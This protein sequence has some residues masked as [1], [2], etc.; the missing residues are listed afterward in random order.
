VTLASRLSSL[1][2]SPAAVYLAAVVLSRA[3]AFLLIPLYTRRLTLEEYGQYALFLTL[4]AFLSTLMSAGL[5]AALPKAY[6]SE[7]DRAAGKRHAAE[8]A[9]WLALISLGGAGILLVGVECV[10][11]P[12]WGDLLG[13][14]TLRLAILGG[15]GTAVSAVPWTLL[16]SEQRPYAASAFQLLQLP[17]ITG[18]GL[19]L[20][21]VL[22][23]GYTGAIEAAALAPMFTGVV[24]LVY[25]I[26][27]PK[28][29]MH[30]TR[31]RRSL[32]FALPFIPLGVL[33]I[34][35]LPRDVA[36]AVMGIY[37][38]VAAVLQVVSHGGAFIRAMQ[39]KT[40]F[41]ISAVLTGLLSGAF[42]A[43]GPASVPFFLSRQKNPLAGQANLSLFFSLLVFPVLGMHILIGGLKP[44]EIL[45]GLPYIPISALATWMAT[46]WIRRMNTRALQLI[47]AAAMALMGLYL[48]LSSILEF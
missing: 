46:R 45:A 14:D 12:D 25:I 38:I 20:V 29:G 9:R 23:R 7:D 17:A 18:A 40:A 43:P 48:A 15:A 35:R 41:G 6:F 19:F 42:S 13:R 44:V 2:R 36:I 47:V 33:F 11:A 21:L 32:R 30:L 34:S 8:V 22:D 27:L 39:T 4:L 24:S 37:V 10:A 28:S 5:V 16:R 31:L 1:W 3:G 26:K